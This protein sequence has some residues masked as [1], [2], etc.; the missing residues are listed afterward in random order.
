RDRDECGAFVGDAEGDAGA[1]RIFR[2]SEDGGCIKTEAGG[3][4]LCADAELADAFGAKRGT[5]TAGVSTAIYLTDDIHVVVDAEDAGEA[6]KQDIV[7]GKVVQR[8][9]HYAEADVGIDIRHGR[10]A[11]FKPKLFLNNNLAEDIYLI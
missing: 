1:G 7:L 5:A 4:D 10:L 9:I 2:E 11:G 8:G 6:V 3:L